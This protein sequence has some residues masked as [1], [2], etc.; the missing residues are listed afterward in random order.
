MTP[1]LKAM[2]ALMGVVVGVCLFVGL[3]HLFPTVF[4]VLVV[5][6]SAGLA[7]LLIYSFLVDYF[8]RKA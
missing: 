7:P 3:A 4:T 5:A 6:S 2:L 1:E 8:E